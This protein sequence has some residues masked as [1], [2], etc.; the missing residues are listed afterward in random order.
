V[1][2]DAVLER[3]RVLGLLPNT[4]KVRVDATHVLADVSRL[5]RIDMVREAIRVVVCDG[6][7]RYPELRARAQFMELYERHGEERWLGTGNSKHDDEELV[8]LGLAGRAVL[9]LCGELEVKDKDVL[10]RILEENFTWT[11]ASRPE[12]VAVDKRPDDHIV[13]PHDPDARGGKKRDKIWTGDKVHVIE[14]AAP[15]EPNL[16]VGVVSTNPRVDDG[17]VLPEIIEQTQE[18]LPG[19]DTLLG[20]AGYASANNS[21]IAAN[22]GIELVAPPRPDSSTNGIRASKFEIDFER[23]VARC[24]EGKES[25]RWSEKQDEITVRFRATDCRVCP[26]R[27]ECTTSKQGRS[28]GIHKQHEQL[29]RDRQRA[30]EP[31]FKELYRLRAPI[32]STFSQLV[33]CVGLRRS[34]YRTAAGRTLHAVLAC[35]ALNVCRMMGR[36]TGQEDAENRAQSGPTMPAAAPVAG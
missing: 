12:P 18:A 13:T 2:F 21:I 7:R 24:P 20:D 15:D 29:A 9:D 11:D 10:A 36:L 30:Q 34:R 22:N 28:L 5:S 35:T 16:I 33:H 32:E 19:V 1:L 23:K 31:E 26:R 14:T 8:A 4:T 17:A 27:E 25:R 3:A 6:H